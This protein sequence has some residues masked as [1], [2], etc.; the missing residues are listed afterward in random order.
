MDPAVFFG[1]LLLLLGIPALTVIT[2]VRLRARRPVSPS[3]DVSGRFEALEAVVQGLQH[4]LSET[5]ERLDFTERLLIEAR[6][7]RQIDS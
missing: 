3:E 2:V 1:A 7:K 6:D 5:Q 4:D